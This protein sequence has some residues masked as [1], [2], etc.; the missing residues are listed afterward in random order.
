MEPIH[1]YEWIKYINKTNKQNML[2]SLSCEMRIPWR[3]INHNMLQNSG[4]NDNNNVFQPDFFS[5]FFQKKKTKNNLIHIFEEH[6]PRRKLLYFCFCFFVHSLL[7]LFCYYFIAYS[8]CLVRDLFKRW[9]MVWHVKRQFQAVQ[10]M[11]E[12]P[13]YC[14]WFPRSLYHV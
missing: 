7:L 10:R 1:I 9:I 3:S 11:E 6:L 4:I 14:H 8:L 2:K 13:S 12:K 5:S